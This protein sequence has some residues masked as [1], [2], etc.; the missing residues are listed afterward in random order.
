[1][2]NLLSLTPSQ[3]QAV[4]F[5][6]LS[7]VCSLE[8]DKMI[9][10]PIEQWSETELMCAEILIDENGIPIGIEATDAKLAALDLL[11]SS[12]LSK[13]SPLARMSILPRQ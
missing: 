13:P 1:M 12:S 5:F 7:D 10:K 2:I 8:G 9:I 11:A 3:L 6:N 4:A